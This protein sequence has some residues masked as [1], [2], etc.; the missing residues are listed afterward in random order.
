MILMAITPMTDDLNIIAALPD[1][2][3][4]EGGMTNA[5]LKAKFDEAGNIIKGYINDTLIPDVHDEIGAAQMRQGNMPIGGTTGQVLCKATDNDYDATWQLSD[6][7]ATP[8]T[9]IKRD[10]DGRAQ[11]ANPAAE[12]DIANRGYVDQYAPKIGDIK[13]TV[14]TDL[15]STWLLC[16][17][18]LPDATQYPDLIAKLPY[19]S[20][21]PATLTATSWTLSQAAYWKGYYYFSGYYN[22]G[23]AYYS[24]LLKISEADLLA[25][26][27]IGTQIWP[28]GTGSPAYSYMGAA[29]CSDSEQLVFVKTSATDTAQVYTSPDGSTWTLVKTFTNQATVSTLHLFYI[30]NKYV[31]CTN[32]SSTNYP[33]VYSADSPAG[34]WTGPITVFST[35]DVINDMAYGNGKYV[36]STTGRRV[37][38]G[39]Q[40]TNWVS[41]LTAIY[42]KLVCFGSNYFMSGR[43]YSTDGVTWT[44]ATAIADNSWNNAYYEDDM[45]V[46]TYNTGAYYAADPAGTWTAF[47]MNFPYDTFRERLGNVIV[48]I[49]SSSNIIGRVNPLRA[50][51]LPTITNKSCYAYIKALEA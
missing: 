1:E 16:N 18:A 51:V 28:G 5:Q 35:S 20:G 17:G 41:D 48:D 21:T 36:I 37:A 50:R 34:P 8:D 27:L 15:D 30:N 9:L 25:G 49:G 4:E 44:T 13:Q 23:S 14:R 2:P 3:T 10:A 11:V 42:G 43:C 45:F 7:T 47:S 29:V 19:A 31:F 33:L 38:V 32:A 26:Q 6:S 46:V 24:G 12:K 22:T 39:D 40:L